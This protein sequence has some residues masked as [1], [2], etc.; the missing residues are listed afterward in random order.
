MP[1]PITAISRGWTWRWITARFLRTG[2]DRPVSSVFTYRKHATTNNAPAEPPDHRI[3]AACQITAFT[4]L[5][6][7]LAS[8]TRGR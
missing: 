8:Q 6:G 2:D 5:G 4:R 1:E 7:L 3:R